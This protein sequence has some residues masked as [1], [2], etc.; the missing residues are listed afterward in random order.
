MALDA[1]T[2]AIAIDLVVFRI[3]AIPKLDNAN[4]DLE[5][6]DSNVTDVCL[7]TGD[8]PKSIRVI[9]DAFVRF[10]TIDRIGGECAIFV[11]MF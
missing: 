2:I 5:L 1:L 11:L 7:V 4:V 6:V 10:S 3:L 9:K 8:C